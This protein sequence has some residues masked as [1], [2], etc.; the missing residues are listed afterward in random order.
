MAVTSDQVIVDSGA[1]TALLKIG[2]NH[3][4]KPANQPYA[5]IPGKKRSVVPRQEVKNGDAD[6]WESFDDPVLKCEGVENDQR[7]VERN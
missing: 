5:G 7:W 3:Q 6:I 1:T 4:A 2:I